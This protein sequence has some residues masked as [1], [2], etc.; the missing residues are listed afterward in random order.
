MA[1]SRTLV[2]LMIKCHHLRF[3]LATDVTFGATEGSGISEKNT[4]L[5]YLMSKEFIQDVYRKQH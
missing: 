1:K 2:K 4:T 5:V 3:S